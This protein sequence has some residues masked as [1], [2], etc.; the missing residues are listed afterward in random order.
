VEQVASHLC[1]RKHSLPHGRS[2][3]YYD[4]KK[5]KFKGRKTFLTAIRP[6][7]STAPCFPIWDILHQEWQ[8]DWCS[9][10]H[11]HDERACRIRGWAVLNATAA[12]DISPGTWMFVKG[13]CCASDGNEMASLSSWIETLCNGSYTSLFKFYDGQARQDWDQ[14]I[15]PDNHTVMPDDMTHVQCPNKS[16][17][18]GLF[19]IENVVFLIFVFMLFLATLYYER[20][21]VRRNQLVMIFH[22]LMSPIR[23]MKTGLK[24]AFAWIFHITSSNDGSAEVIET[25]LL[26]IFLA[27]VQ[28]AFNFASAVV[29]QRTPGYSNVDIT[30]LA[31][32]FCSRPRIGWLACLLSLI[33]D[34]ALEQWFHMTEH[35]SLVSG[36]KIVARVAVSS[37][38]GEVMMQLL[39]SYFLGMTAHVGVIRGFYQH[40]HLSPFENGMQARNMYGGAM[41]WVVAAFFIVV[42]WIIVVIWHALIMQFFTVTASW[43]KET[44][45]STLP[46][47]RVTK[48][49]KKKER[50]PKTRRSR[51]DDPLEPSGLFPPLTGGPTMRGGAQTP[52]QDSYGSGGIFR[53]G[54]DTPSNPSSISVGEGPIIR[55]GD[56]RQRIQVA[57]RSRINA[58]RNRQGSYQAVSQDAIMRA[59]DLP[60]HRTQE[61]EDASA[62]LHRPEDFDIGIR[63]IPRNVGADV[64]PFADSGHIHRGPTQTHF[65][66][67]T[68]YHGIGGE[69]VGD[70]E[71]VEEV[72]EDEK[73][74]SFH[75]DTKTHIPANF[76]AWQ[77]YILGLGIFLGILSYIAQWLFWSGFVNT[78]GD[79]SVSIDF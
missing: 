23:T 74:G 15:L 26:A 29:V 27:G 36:Q 76:R 54:T 73:A 25:I 14:Y 5:S 72:E 51:R 31:F 6:C 63:Q 45:A 8:Q 11:E 56:F 77:P 53:P 58:S 55:P 18:L 12:C 34:W 22:R 21:F 3:V 61:Y 39:G 35:A 10:C 32:L 7:T 71:E 42:M 68:A 59:D 64:D 33:P 1:Q 66:R 13:G 57:P 78:S 24:S 49:W 43:M 67:D 79:R 70:E 69:E 38:M 50:N 17:Y 75:W 41:L 2:V 60:D 47:N 20:G 4:T 40:N 65:Q 9:T 48:T 16:L 44:A 62:P 28:L 37:A 30:L 52:G 19:A 46:G